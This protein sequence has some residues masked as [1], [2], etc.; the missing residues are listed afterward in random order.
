MNVIIVS[1]I[2]PNSQEPQ[3]GMFTYQIVNELRQFCHV[4]VVAPVPWIPRRLANRGPRKFLHAFV[5][6]CEEMDGITVYHPRY[7]V[8]PRMGFTHAVSMAVPILGCLKV[9]SK[10]HPIDLI[11]AHWVFPDGVAAVWAGRYLQRPTVLTALGCDINLYATMPARRAQIIWAMKNACSVTSVASSLKDAIV[12]LGIPEKKVRVV[13]NG[14]NSGTFKI[15]DR[16]ACRRNLS[17]PENKKIILTVGSQDEVKGTCALIEA[18]ARLVKSTR[19]RFV[20]ALVGDGP[21]RS[22]LEQ[23]TRALGVS[24]SVIFAGSRPHAEISLW[25]N[26]A[27]VFCLPSLRE[28][29]PNV[30]IESMA[31]GTPVVATRVGEICHMLNSRSGLIVPIGDA[32]TLSLALKEALNRQWSRTEIRS[33][34]QGHDWRQCAL[35]YYESYQELLKEKA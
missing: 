27:D 30:V 7:L 28:G 15:M 33:G 18:F 13:P 19:S 9:I 5:P 11:N 32:N 6:G 20:L 25:M 16:I 23:Q 1:N 8:V 34:V 12:S 10:E 3:R 2:F 4:D 24:E 17:L 35:H 31:C 29:H 14:V 26:A 21:L 22:K